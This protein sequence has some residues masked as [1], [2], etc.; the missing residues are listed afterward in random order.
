MI[1]TYYSPER[2]AFG[3][4]LSVLIVKDYPLLA[5][6]RNRIDAKYGSPEKS[7][8][9]FEGNGLLINPLL[10]QGGTTR[11]TRSSLLGMEACFFM[12]MYK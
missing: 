3:C 6:N 10:N 5:A 4:K 9:M 12:S 1:L 2:K 7:V 8:I 11:S